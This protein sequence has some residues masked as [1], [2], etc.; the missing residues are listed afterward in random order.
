MQVVGMA[1][2]SGFALERLRKYFKR[3]APA[4]K[5]FRTIFSGAARRHGTRRNHLPRGA[6]AGG[7]GGGGRSKRGATYKYRT[8]RGA[9]CG[10]VRLCWCVR[11]AIFEKTVKPETHSQ[12]IITVDVLGGLFTMSFSIKVLIIKALTR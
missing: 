10:V 7:M 4:A 9:F 2:V 12:I 8:R 6:G 5:I 1:T 11:C 3:G